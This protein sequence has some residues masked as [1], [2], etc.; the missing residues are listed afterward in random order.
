MPF[1]IVEQKTVPR[2]QLTHATAPLESLQPDHRAVHVHRAD[3]VHV[4]IKSDR[5]VQ[6]FVGL[7]P[8]IQ[9]HV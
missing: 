8:K 9:L 7:R 2:C 3:A 4:D 1:P 6:G 5:N